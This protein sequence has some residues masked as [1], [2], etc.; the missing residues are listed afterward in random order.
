L[1][2]TEKTLQVGSNPVKV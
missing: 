2:L 1:K